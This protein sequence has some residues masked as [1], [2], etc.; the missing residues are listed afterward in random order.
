VATSN[1]KNRSSLLGKKLYRVP[2]ANC[3]RGDLLHRNAGEPLLSEQ[4][5]SRSQDLLPVLLA[6]SVVPR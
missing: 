5:Q 6:F 4:L 2:V 1:S 3:G